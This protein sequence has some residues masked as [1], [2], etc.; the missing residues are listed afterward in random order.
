[1]WC[2]FVVAELVSANSSILIRFK[3][4]AR[5]NVEV[6]N[7]GNIDSDE[8]VQFDTMYVFSASKVCMCLT[9]LGL[10]HARFHGC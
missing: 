7:L 4:W 10:Q 9:L 1:M 2:R 5:N 6:V 3:E 8:A